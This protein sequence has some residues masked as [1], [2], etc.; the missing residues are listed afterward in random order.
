MRFKPRIYRFET[1]TK[2]VRE[3][4]GILSSNHKGKIEIACPPEFGGQGGYW[5][6]EHLF[7]ASI[8]ICIMTTF[9]WLMEKNNAKII[10]YE[11]E[12]IGTAQMVNSNFRFNRVEIRPVIIVPDKESLLKAKDAIENAHKH[13]LISKALNFE[14]N[15][16]PV[17]KCNE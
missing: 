17:I 2:W 8:E 6:A 5:T 14:V 10:A 3:R 12:S 11:S 9:K 15:V 13:C 7:V 16:N 1:N 4:R